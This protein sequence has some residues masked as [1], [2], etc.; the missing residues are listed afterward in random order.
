MVEGAEP[1]ITG[2]YPKVNCKICG[3][4]EVVFGVD[5]EGLAHASMIFGRNQQNG[6][7]GERIIK[8]Y[9]LYAGDSSGNKLPGPA[10]GEAQVDASSEVC[11]GRAYN[12]TASFNLTESLPDSVVIVPVD[13]SDYEMPVGH[14]FT[15]NP[16]DF[17]MGIDDVV[18]VSQARHPAYLIGPLAVVM[19]LLIRMEG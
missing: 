6:Q 10:Q 1:E 9:R 17:G 2:E 8:S 5:S 14:H 18:F 15:L 7:V 19:F 13:T 12:M 11:C 3:I 16:A 4:H